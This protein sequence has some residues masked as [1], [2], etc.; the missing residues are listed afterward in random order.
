MPLQPRLIH[1]GY[2]LGE[3]SFETKRAL[4]RKNRSLRQTSSF[5]STSDIRKCCYLLFFSNRS[6]CVNRSIEQTSLILSLSVIRK[7][8]YYLIFSKSSH[9]WIK[10]N[11]HGTY[12][13]ILLLLQNLTNLLPECN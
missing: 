7:C 6:F 8:C 9:S 2:F 10:K 11:I 5:L 13:F 12:L 1:K 3:Q 4:Y